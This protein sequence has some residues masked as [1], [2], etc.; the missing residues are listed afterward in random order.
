MRLFTNV[1]LKS[2]S[3]IYLWA[4]LNVNKCEFRATKKGWWVQAGVGDEETLKPEHRHFF[5]RYI[6]QGEVSRVL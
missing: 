3:F 1:C 2:G 5:K 4:L 6:F